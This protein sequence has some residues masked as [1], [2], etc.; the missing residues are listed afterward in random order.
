M[1]DV[2]VRR[3]LWTVGT[4]V[5]FFLYTRVVFPSPLAIL[6]L[7]GVLGALN[8]LVAMG[9]ILVYRANR[10]INF[11][12][13]EIGAL[14]GLLGVLLVSARGWPYFVGL[15]VGLTSALIVGGVA[16]FL[17][18]RRFASAPR[19]ILTVATIGIAQLLSAFE[20]ILPRAFGRDLANQQFPTPFNFAF[21]W[22]PVVF[23]GNHV[24]AVLVVVASG[25]ALSAF[26]RRSRFGVAVRAAA[27]STERAAQLGINTKRVGT[28]VWV[29]AGGLSAI[30]FFLRAPIVGLPIGQVLG[31]SLL[32]RALAAAVIARME[33]L[34]VALGVAITLGMFEQATL[35][36]SSRG[37]AF[38]GVLFGLIMAALIFQRRGKVARAD[39]AGGSSWDLVKEVRPVP[40]ELRNVR[41][42]MWGKQ[43][44]F[45][46]LVGALGILPL[47]LR[48]SKV[49]LMGIGLTW[50]MVGVSM[51]VLTGWAGEISFGQMAFFG[52]GM[53][54]A[55]K[56][57]SLDWNF[58]ACLFV[59]GLMGA[60][61]SV[62][63]G[64]PALRIRGPFLAVATFAFALAASTYFLNKEAFPRLIIDR[65]V[66]RPILFER[67]NLESEHTYYYFLLIMLGLVVLSARAIRRSR[68]GRVLI[69]SRDNP[70][71]AQA[72][73][74]SVLRARLVAFAFSGFYAALAGA[75]VAYHQHNLA[76]STYAV[77]RSLRAFTMVVFGG[78][79]SIPGVI[80][81]S[82][83]YTGIDYF[84]SFPGT[85]LLVSGVGLLLVLMVVPGGLSQLLYDGRDSLLR[86]LARRRRIVVPSLVADQRVE[87]E[88]TP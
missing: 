58:F 11:A 39:E 16:E 77:E 68:I 7:G 23:R 26:L 62:L 24:M 55:L 5:A 72:F 83:Y 13:G 60:A 28:L 25:V 69:A 14:G 6:A 37:L 21:T 4:V 41:E 32:L 3:A 29:I 43:V 65:R 67:F 22:S 36:R 73:G 45:F 27:E 34:G 18:V 78:L 76:P 66:T 1:S 85:Q 79:G 57:D 44:V 12:Q 59:A 86:R 30:A 80:I 17:F 10:I 31:P 75:L 47:Y 88:L 84:S 35:W 33:R 87:E 51:V 49:N 53:A 52:V 70:R 64:I 56:L 74:V 9:L 42:V 40:P 19:L 20:L 15:A 46:F 81:G 38:D 61:A 82:A 50:A 8:G 71:A 2:A 54:T 63:I 48:V